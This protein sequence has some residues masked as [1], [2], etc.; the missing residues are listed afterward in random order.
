LKALFAVPYINES[1]AAFLREVEEESARWKPIV[2]SL[3]I[4]LD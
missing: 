1:P 4:K 2:D 3:N